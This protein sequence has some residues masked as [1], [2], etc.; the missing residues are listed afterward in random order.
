MET[1]LRPD[2]TRATLLRGLENCGP[3]AQHIAGDS[4]PCPR[5][6]PGGDR[7]MVPGTSESL[8]DGLVEGGLVPRWNHDAEVGTGDQVGNPAH[9]GSDDRCAAGESFMDHV[10]PSLAIAGETEHIGRGEP[11]GHGFGAYP[12]GKVDM[13]CHAGLI[14]SA[15]DL[16]R[17]RG[18]R[19]ASHDHQ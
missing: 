18:V 15:P 5:H 13:L 9:I 2:Y 14:D 10:G 12:P 19:T 1:N 17:E 16:G 7:S 8:T 4:I 11:L 3:F 6:S